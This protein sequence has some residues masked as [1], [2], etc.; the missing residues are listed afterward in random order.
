[1]NVIE[2]GNIASGAADFILETNSSLSSI[3]FYGVA[4]I[5]TN[6]DFL[7]PY[8]IYLSGSALLEINTTT[9]DAELDAFARRGSGRR[10]LLGRATPTTAR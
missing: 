1:M 6:F 3:Q 5:A 4:A 2:I 10:G 7:Q 8:G 9:T